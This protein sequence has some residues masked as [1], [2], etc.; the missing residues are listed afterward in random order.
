MIERTMKFR[1]RVL[2][3]LLITAFI[4]VATLAE[5]NDLD[6]DDDADPDMMD[7][8]DMMDDDMMDGDGDM[9]DGDMMDGDMD[10]GPAMDDDVETSDDTSEEEEPKVPR[11]RVS[12]IY[13][14]NICKWY[15]MFKSRLKYLFN[16]HH[17]VNMDVNLALCRL[18]LLMLLTHS[19][20]KSYLRKGMGWTFCKRD[21]VSDVLPKQL[22]TGC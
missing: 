11:V 5:D 4:A 20:T 3:L 16:V 19:C 22:F 15:A 9:M 1:L 6:M 18:M 10:E 14:N 17:T 2:R 21:A 12:F 13:V 8:D 7:S